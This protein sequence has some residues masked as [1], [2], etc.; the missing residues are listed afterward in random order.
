MYYVRYSFLT[1]VWLNDN[2]VLVSGEQKNESDYTHTDICI[3][4]YIY[5]IY[6][7]MCKYVFIC[8]FSDFFPL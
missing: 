4:V 1:E 7:C 3:C 8:T 2:S 5:K 6:L